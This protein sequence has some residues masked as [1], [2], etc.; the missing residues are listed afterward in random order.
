LSVI[1]I[2]EFIGVSLYELAK[3][4]ENIL[5]HYRPFE[6]EKFF[7]A[8]DELKNVKVVLIGKQGGEEQI[9]FIYNDVER[10]LPLERINDYY[11]LCFILQELR[12]S[13]DN[14][15]IKKIALMLSKKI[16]LEEARK[17]LE[18]KALAVE[19]YV[20][21][22][23]VEVEK[24]KS[25]IDM[26]SVKKRKDALALYLALRVLD[27]AI[28]YY[29]EPESG[30]KGL[31]LVF[32]E[33]IYQEG[34]G[35]ILAIAN[36]IATEEG[37]ID[38]LTNQVRNNILAHIK[39][40]CILA[41][42]RKDLKRG[43]Y[44]AFKNGVLDLEEF[45]KTG[46]IELKPFDPNLYILWKIPHELRVEEYNMLDLKAKTNP[47]EALKK[48]D[49]GLYKVMSDWFDI[50]L[51]KAKEQYPE[52][53]IKLAK[54]I[55]EI[56]GSRDNLV[57]LILQLYGDTLYPDIRFDFIRI[58]YSKETLTGKSTCLGL[59]EH[60]LGR[61]NVS[62]IPL[63]E[64]VEDIFA[65]IGLLGKLANIFTDLPEVRVKKQGIIKQ[66]VSG[67]PI[68]ANVKHKNRIKFR[69]IAK[70]FYSCNKLPRVEDI[71]DKAYMRRAL[72][73]PFLRKFE[74]NENFKKYI[75]SKAHKLIIPL[76]IALRDIELNGLVIDPAKEEI[77]MKI[78]EFYQLKLDPVLR[79]L[80]EME[81]RGVLV[82]DPNGRVL[83]DDLL[84]L[85]NKWAEANDEATMV[86]NQFTKALKKH[87][88][89]KVTIKGIRYYKGIK[90]LKPK[91]EAKK[92]LEEYL[93][94]EEIPES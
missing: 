50:D 10:T 11:A 38:N 34:E 13:E 56:A 55:Y 16:V 4:D 81:E 3:I 57:K 21:S 14:S 66:I 59:L 62:N 17:V 69:P 90:L 93:E 37:L 49:P 70:H 1:E 28:P 92:T 23:K 51:E 78:K 12:I 27:E 83:D 41:K 91:D 46:R 26:D 31:L 86:M 18:A 53:D 60:V 8:I 2:T 47:V 32:R 24:R 39:E 36:K 64:L 48:I 9:K 25:K 67:E 71:E 79:F 63:Q 76:L 19:N 61:D 80:K 82:R 68:S 22:L 94:S 84:E 20:S 43:K 35:Y 44:I 72:I 6:T 74:R 7:R 88:I 29:I 65:R 77:L 87:G 30:K 73:I 58:F 15:V 52:E 54:L 33:G 40:I 45:I 5:S 85:Y 75:F 42:R 89:R